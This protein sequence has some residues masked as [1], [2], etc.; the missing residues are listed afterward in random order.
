MILDPVRLAP[1]EGLTIGRA[2][3]DLKMS[4]S[5]RFD[6]LGSNQE[7]ADCSL[8]DLERDT[9]PGGCSLTAAGAAFDGRRGPVRDAMA[10]PGRAWGRARA[11]RRLLG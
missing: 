6:H 8:A 7:L 11:D 3:S 9:P 5:G 10:E 4:K 2:A 1:L